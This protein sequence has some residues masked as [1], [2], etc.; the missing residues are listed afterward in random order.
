[1]E[2]C[3]EGL[4]ALSR[5]IEGKKIAGE[6]VRL[7]LENID[8]EENPK[9]FLTSVARGFEII[10]AVNHP[11]VQFCYDLFHEQISEGN[12]IE[13]LQRNIQHVGLIH[14]ADVPG[15]HKPG[16][17]EINYA[18]IYRKLVELK[19]NHVVAMEFLPLGDPVEELRVAREMAMALGT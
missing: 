7:L 5:V 4:K 16:T 15:R 9:Y 2:S 19:Y 8:P 18:S 1:V 6:S 3:V 13:K 14:V 12:L 10:K 11:Q 17:G